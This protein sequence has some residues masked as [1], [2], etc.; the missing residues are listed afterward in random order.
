M[1]QGRVKRKEYLQY[2]LSVRKAER[3]SELLGLKIKPKTI[4]EIRA[5]FE[6]EYG[7]IY[8]KD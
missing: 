4:E 7:S 6:G 5:E 8:I 1:A 2:L 3:H